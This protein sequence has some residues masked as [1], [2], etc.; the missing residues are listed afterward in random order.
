MSI[1]VINKTS[2]K[3]KQDCEIDKLVFTRKDK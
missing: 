1:L 2:E 3:N